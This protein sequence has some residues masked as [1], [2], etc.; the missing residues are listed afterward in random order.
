MK[1]MVIITLVMVALILGFTQ[2]SKAAE[3]TE[4]QNSYTNESV[5]ILTKYVIMDNAW[6]TL[7]DVSKS[8]GE[9][10]T[11][12][13]GYDTYVY[14]IEPIDDYRFLLAGTGRDW[15]MSVIFILDTRSSDFSKLLLEEGEYLDKYWALNNGMYFS[16]TRNNTVLVKYWNYGGNPVKIASFSQKNNVV[17]IIFGCT[18]GISEG[19]GLMVISGKKATAYRL[20]DKNLN[21]VKKFPFPVLIMATDIG[22]YISKAN[23]IDY[24][25]WGFQSKS[26]K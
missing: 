3:K 15:D 11:I 6:L 1:K 20:D 18:E 16:F 24:W 22:F 14:S 17:D 8:T 10:T 19:T 2:V 5:N 4:F 21:L 25:F 7:A 9:S 26:I 23:Q 13:L 12:L